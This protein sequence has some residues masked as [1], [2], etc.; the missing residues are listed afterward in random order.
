M[1][2]CA[3]PEARSAAAAELIRNRMHGASCP[4][5]LVSGGCA[6]GAG[7]LLGRRRELAAAHAEAEWAAVGQALIEAQ[8]ADMADADADQAIVRDQA[9]GPLDALDV[10]HAAEAWSSVLTG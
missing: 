8:Q 6:A 3:A 4:R 10:A 5:M 9:G 1:L 7:A 2:L